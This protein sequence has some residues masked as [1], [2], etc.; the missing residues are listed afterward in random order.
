MN[1]NSIAI[2]TD[3]CSDVPQDLLE[4]FRIYQMPLSINYKD[5]SYRDRIDI[6]PEEVYKNLTI[7]IPHTSLPSMGEIHE[8]IEKIIADGFD[9][10]IIP[11]ISSGLSGTYNAIQMA[12]S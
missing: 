10:I 7:E 8:L 5:R 9:K 1:E 11:V 4:R 12:V 6:T 3:S 2:L